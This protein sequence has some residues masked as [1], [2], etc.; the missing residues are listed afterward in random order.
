[1]AL[2]NVSL[3]PPSLSCLPYITRSSVFFTF[4]SLISPPC[5]LVSLISLM[6]LHF[7]G[8]QSHILHDPSPHWVFSLS[9]G[10]LT[11]W[12]LSPSHDHITLVGPRSLVTSHMVS[13][14]PS[15]AH[16][17][18]LTS[19]YVF[20]HSGSSDCKI[21]HGPLPCYFLSLLYLGLLCLVGS[22]VFVTLCM[23]LQLA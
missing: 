10:P 13:H 20:L 11:C 21:S 1:M 6:V 15:Q 19:D 2:P 12:V 18:S 22:S 9:H 5:W 4:C 3:G 23:A 8:P 16:T 17:Q 14:G 7:L